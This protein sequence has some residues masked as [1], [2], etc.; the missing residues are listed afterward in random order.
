MENLI[1]ADKFGFA[2]KCNF[3]EAIFL[4]KLFIFKKLYYR[5]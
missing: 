5:L 1:F 4:M 3:K 2:R